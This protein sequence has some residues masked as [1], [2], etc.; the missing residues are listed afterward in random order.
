LKS[1]AP[2]RR[3]TRSG[4]NQSCLRKRSAESNAT[5]CFQSATEFD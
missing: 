5:E 2:G 3:R 1:R 4:Q